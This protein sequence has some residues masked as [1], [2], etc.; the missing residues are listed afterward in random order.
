MVS[1]LNAMGD[2]TCR[3]LKAQY[4]NTSVQNFE[5]QGSFGGSGVIKVRQA[6]KKG[7]I[8]CVNGGGL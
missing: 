1:S 3:L 5:S 7:Y 6:T 8:E 2:G 4:G